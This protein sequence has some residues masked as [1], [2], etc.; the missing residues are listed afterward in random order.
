MYS[1]QTCVIT[2]LFTLVKPQDDPLCARYIERYQQTENEYAVLYNQSFLLYHECNNDLRD[3][4]NQQ[5]TEMTMNDLMQKQ[6]QESDIRLRNCSEN[7][8]YMSKDNTLLEMRVRTLNQTLKRNII[9]HETK[10]NNAY[11]LINEYQRNTT[12]L[13]NFIDSLIE[14]NDINL[15]ALNDC[16]A[17][18]KLTKNQIEKEKS[19]SADFVKNIQD[20]LEREE[21]CLDK[22]T[23]LSLSL[24][25]CR[26]DKRKLKHLKLYKNKTKLL[27]H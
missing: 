9:L 19:V 23:K 20:C 10:L 18:L 11:S 21:T 16:T 24:S 25:T 22:K 5:S 7:L 13:V 15:L 1:L 4:L 27:E 3:C 17:D 8:N 12:K 2:L 6:N 26:S 14:S